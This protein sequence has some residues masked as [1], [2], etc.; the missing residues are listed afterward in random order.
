MRVGTV[1]RVRGC[2]WCRQCVGTEYGADNERVCMVPAMSGCVWCRQS[3]GGYGA[4]SVWV[5]GMAPT[6]SGC[7]S[8]AVG[9]RTVL[10]AKARLAARHF[11]FENKEHSNCRRA[12][13]G[14]K[15]GRRTTQQAKPRFLREVRGLRAVISS[16]MD[17]YCNLFTLTLQSPI[18]SSSPLLR[19][20]ALEY[21]CS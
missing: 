2:V 10:R 19:V 1:P 7:K 12:V 20:S 15:V 13:R 11:D 4:D 6:M 21:H 18:A 3:A 8:L 5:L 9:E 14:G 17:A 16:S